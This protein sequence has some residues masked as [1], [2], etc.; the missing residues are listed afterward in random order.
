MKKTSKHLKD[1]LSPQ[2]DVVIVGSG[3]AGVNAAYPLVKA[4]LKVAIID[5]GLDSKKQD[6]ELIDLSDINLTETS[7]AYNLLRR[8]SYVFNK[9]YQLLRVK[10]KF[11]IIQSLAKG[12]L[13]E[14]WHG[15]S[16]FFSKDELEA[17]GLPSKEIQMEYQEI[18]DSIKLKL[19]TELDYHGQLILQNSK[20]RGSLKST[21]YQVPVAFSY[22]TKSVIEDLKGFK[23]F[24][25][26]PNQL[27]TTIKDRGKYVKIQSFSIDQDVESTTNTRF[28]ILAAG[29][30]NSTRILLRSFNLYNYKT[31]FLTKAHY[32]IACLHARTLFSPLR[33]PRP[34]TGGEDSFKKNVAKRKTRF[35]QVG[36]LSKGNVQGIGPFFIQLYRFNPLAIHKILKYIP[37]PKLISLRLM[38]FI[39]PSLVI[40]DVRFP[41]SESKNKY[42]KLVK[43]S[44][45]KDVLEISFKET[46]KELK[47]HQSELSKIKRELRALGLFPLKVTSDYVTA[48]YAGGVPF[49]NVQGRLS[50]DSNGK[51]HQAKRIYIADSSTWR[52]ISAKPLALTIMANASRIGKEV[53]KISIK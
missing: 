37:V 39:A 52:A 40:A 38:P 43:E 31:T 5:G 44:N 16:D 8:S 25:Y 9:T 51:L 18:T 30:I 19:Q 12:G 4:G 53:L 14:V 23:N 22:R 45:G 50:V 35:G 34:S 17:I 7:N 20:K 1:N 47:S 3:P 36:I 15:I 28:L 48:H 46:I 21:V 6:K 13:S 33:I 11:E 42:C 41:S 26:I 49:K 27:V 29:S 32:L 2:F 24:T 10:S